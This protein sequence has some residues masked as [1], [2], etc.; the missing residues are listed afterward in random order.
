MR[1]L[2]EDIADRSS[3]YAHVDMSRVAV[4]F[5]QARSRA[6]HGLQATLTPLRFK[7]GARTVERRGKLWRI[8]PILDRQGHEMLYLLSF[9]LPRF[10]DQTLEEKLTTV[11]H[12]LWH[13]G[14]AFDGDLRRHDGRCY[15]HGA[16][17]REYDEQVRRHA[18]RWLALKPDSR[19]YEFLR[20]DFAQL[21]RR[22][23]AVRGSHIR[24]P[25]IVPLQA[26]SSA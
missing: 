13:I 20:H 3:E 21:R 6:R 19:L 8:E 18:R 25:R 2:C 9:Y 11:F 10:L 24:A 14:P 17:G 12:E 1:R 5:C 23:G 22:F 26:R 16:S 7:G 15:A 4:R